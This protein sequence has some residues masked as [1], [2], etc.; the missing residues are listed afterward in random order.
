MWPSLADATDCRLSWATSGLSGKTAMPAGRTA[1]SVLNQA[2]QDAQHLLGIAK[3]LRSAEQERIAREIIRDID[4]LRA[5]HR[6]PAM[7]S[8]DGEA[9]VDTEVHTTVVT[10]GAGGGPAGATLSVEPPTR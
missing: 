3:R 7:S 2:T 4:A 6:L 9:G 8:G 10:A 1:L 5:K